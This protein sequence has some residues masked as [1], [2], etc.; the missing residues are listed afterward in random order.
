MDIIIVSILLTIIVFAIHYIYKTK[1]KG[2]KCVGCPYD[3][4]NCPS[5]IE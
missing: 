5:K 3:C 1:K 2:K 4:S